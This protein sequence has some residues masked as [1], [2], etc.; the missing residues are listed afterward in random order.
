VLKSKSQLSAEL[1]IV[2]EAS[3]VNEKLHDDLSSFGVAPAD[4]A[5]EECLRA[6]GYLQ[7]R[8][9]WWHPPSCLASW[10]LREA[11]T[12]AQKDEAKPAHDAG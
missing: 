12:M 3:M 8:R 6:G 1:L 7:N 11:Y 9:G 5:M 4:D 2:D 10:P